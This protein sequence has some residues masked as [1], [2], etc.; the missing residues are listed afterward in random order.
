MVE[1]LP[2]WF[3]VPAIIILWSMVGYMYINKKGKK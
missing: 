1:E 2:N 3:S